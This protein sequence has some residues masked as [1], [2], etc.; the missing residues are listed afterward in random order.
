MTLA[1]ATEL[2][3][4]ARFH[5]LMMRKTDLDNRQLR[6]RGSRVSCPAVR[7][8][9]IQFFM[10]LSLL[11]GG[12]VLPALA[13]ADAGSAD[14][15]IEMLD[16]H[17]EHADDDDRASKTSPGDPD[18]AVHHHCTVSLTLAAGDIAAAKRLARMK[19][20]PVP[21]AAMSS[22]DTAPLTEPP[23]A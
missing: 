15:A 13:H 8:Y 9:F 2:A 14:H 3:P 4:L 5:L 1:A 20:R 6:N 7:R 11:F 22:R 10:V 12:A 18:Q 21:A 16:T 19:E 17:H 23:S